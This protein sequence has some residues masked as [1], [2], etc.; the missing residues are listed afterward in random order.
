MLE[1]FAVTYL[2]AIYKQEEITT[3][4][5]PDEQ[6]LFTQSTLYP[7]SSPPNLPGVENKDAVMCMKT[8]ATISNTAHHEY[9]IG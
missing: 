6:Q 5:C 3:N 4:R 2:S 7:L 1:Q 9:R 8:K